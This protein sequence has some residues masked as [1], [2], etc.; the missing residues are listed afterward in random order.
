L[1]VKVGSSQRGRPD[2]EVAIALIFG[3]RSAIDAAT[4]SAFSNTGT[5]HVLSVSGLH[6]GLVFGFL[7]LLLGSVDRFRYGKVLRC[8]LILLSVWS[9][10]ILTGMAP[11]ILRAGIMISFFLLS[12][13]VRRKQVPLNTLAAS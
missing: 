5:S 1:L 10:V 6:V 8:G 2:C 11:P 12:L 9:Y 3:S 4:L 7:T 13:M